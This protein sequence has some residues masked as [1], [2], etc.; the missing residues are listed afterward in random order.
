MTHS[1]DWN[2]VKENN[3]LINAVDQC[4][5]AYHHVCATA[6]LLLSLLVNFPLI[7]RFNLI[8]YI[9]YFNKGNNKYSHMYFI[10]FNCYAIYAVLVCVWF[11]GAARF[12]V[13]TCEHI[14]VKYANHSV[15]LFLYICSMF[16][17]LS[18]INVYALAR[19]TKAQESICVR[20]TKLCVHLCLYI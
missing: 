5:L 8:D 14:I 1:I 13:W 11:T 3:Q 19:N 17:I 2:W 16:I 18:V 6:A 9:V 12:I 10:S 4:K 7:N 20:I 15:L